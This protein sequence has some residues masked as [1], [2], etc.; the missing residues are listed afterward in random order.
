MN[1]TTCD[2]ANKMQNDT[3]C[4]KGNKSHSISSRF[5]KCLTQEAMQ[6][7][8][9]T[10]S[11]LRHR[12]VRYLWGAAG[13]LSFVLGTLGAILPL[14]PTTPFILLAAFCFARSSQKLNDWFRSTKLYHTVFEG[15]LTKK[16]MTLSAKL[17][18]L[19]PICTLLLISFM[20]MSSVPAGRIVVAV[21]FI[22]HIVYFG[23]MVKTEKSETNSKRTFI[24]EPTAE[25]GA[26]S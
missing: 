22:G 21:I 9:N 15:L 7:D 24:Y 16:A 12:T 25:P 26:E 14:I 18:L 2:I 11:S 3:P 10:S 8:S 20:M 17:K 6:D 5:A 23:F 1:K 13:L 19:I 4:E